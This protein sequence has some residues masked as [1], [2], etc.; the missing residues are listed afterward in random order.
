MWLLVRVMR[1]GHRWVV[2]ISELSV[3]LRVVSWVVISE[4]DRFGIL[5]VMV[6]ERLNLDIVHIVAVFR[7]NITV[8][9]CV[10]LMS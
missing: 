5:K 6:L 10:I 7:L 3:V 2:L 8:A 4:G 9:M 1:H